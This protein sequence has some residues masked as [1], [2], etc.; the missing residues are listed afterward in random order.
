MA[1]NLLFC[2]WEQKLFL[3]NTEGENERALM[4]FSYLLEYK[5]QFGGN[6][7]LSE[8]KVE[9]LDDNIT[10]LTEN[11]DSAHGLLTFMIQKKAITQRQQESVSA[12]SESCKRNEVLLEIIRRS[13]Q[14]QLE[15]TIEALK[16]SN[17][18]SI[19]DVLIHGGSN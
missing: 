7:P 18:E 1:S 4:K 17:Q 11:I 12:Q 14:S 3:T 2:L 5:P 10:F 13:S 9:I 16:A 15:G 6:W 8:S 19:A